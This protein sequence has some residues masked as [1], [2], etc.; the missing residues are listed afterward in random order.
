MTK[1]LLFYFLSPFFFLSNPYT[2]S[3]ALRDGN[4]GN[5]AFS[6]FIFTVAEKRGLGASV[7]ESRVDE[8]GEVVAGAMLA[9]ACEGEGEDVPAL[10]QEA[11][12]TRAVAAVEGEGET[13]IVKKDIDDKKKR[14][15]KN[16]R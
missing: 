4:D 2:T 5:A 7:G 16:K 1:I 11:L 12:P 13:T 3:A 10:L 14:I 6:S 9:V 15:K 8:G